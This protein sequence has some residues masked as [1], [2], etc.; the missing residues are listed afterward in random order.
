MKVFIYDN[1]LNLTNYTNALKNINVDYVLTKNTSLLSDTN[2]LLLTGGGNIIP[3]LYDKP[4]LRSYYYDPETDLAELYLIKQFVKSKKTI[5]GICKGMQAINVFFGGTLKNVENHFFTEKNSL[6]EITN[7]KSS[8]LLPAFNKT[9]KVNSCHVE[10]LDK[11]APC[12]SVS[13]KSNDGTVEALHHKTLPI[14]GVQFHPERMSV[15]FSNRFFSSLLL[16]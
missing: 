10:Q 16:K 1:G 15:Y 14:Y 8:F 7:T 6:H 11:I 5:I 13:A 9:I 12:L 4:V 3:Y 2:A